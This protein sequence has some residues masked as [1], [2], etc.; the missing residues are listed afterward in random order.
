MNTEKSQ[1]DRDARLLELPSGIG[2]VDFHRRPSTRRLAGR[3]GS[4]RNR[5][6]DVDPLDEQGGLRHSVM[7]DAAVAQGKCCMDLY[8]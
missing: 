3:F 7:G 1:A 6:P 5:L 8:S 2:S 4:T